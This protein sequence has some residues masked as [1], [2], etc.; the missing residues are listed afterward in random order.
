M[1]G[2]LDFLN[3]IRTP[4]EKAKTYEEIMI[5]IEDE[6]VLCIHDVRGIC[7]CKKECVLANRFK[8][9]SKLN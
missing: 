1:D 7:C 4:L 6:C 5:A 8:K 2:Q 3:L 9:K